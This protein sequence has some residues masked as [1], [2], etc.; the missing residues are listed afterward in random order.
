MV[1]FVAELVDLAFGL[2]GWPILRR[3]SL[4]A[5]SY[6]TVYP[7]ALWLA[8]SQKTYDTHESGQCAA[9]NELLSAL[10]LDD[11]PIQSDALHTTQSF[12]D[13]VCS[14]V[15]MFSWPLTRRL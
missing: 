10:V 8:L 3:T 4:S 1:G 15:R 14:R 9:I 2:G 6:V 12:L 5:N 7:R 13:G 11:L